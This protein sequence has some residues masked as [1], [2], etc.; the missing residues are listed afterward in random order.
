MTP[1]VFEVSVAVRFLA[2]AQPGLVNLIFIVLHSLGPILP[3]PLP[4][5]TVTALASV[6]SRIGLAVPF[7]QTSCTVT[8]SFATGVR[9]EPD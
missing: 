8:A 5:E 6:V 4:P 7:K 3:S 9:K 1:G 2:V